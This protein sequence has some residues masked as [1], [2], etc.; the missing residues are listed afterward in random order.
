MVMSILAAIT[1][2]YYMPLAITQ[3]LQVKPDYYDA[4]HRNLSDPECMECENKDKWYVWESCS[5]CFGAFLENPDYVIQVSVS[6]IKS[7][8][9]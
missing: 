4:N 1:I 7:F 2:S 3:V 5:R 8:L 6:F 9:V